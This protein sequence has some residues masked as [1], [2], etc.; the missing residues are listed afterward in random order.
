MFPTKM[1]HLTGVL[2]NKTE[3]FPWQRIAEMQEGQDEN[4][5]QISFH[6]RIVPFHPSSF[7]AASRLP[8]FSRP[9]SLNGPHKLKY[10]VATTRSTDLWPF[11]STFPLCLS[12]FGKIDVI[13]SSNI[14]CIV[15]C[16][17]ELLWFDLLRML[18]IIKP[19]VRII[20]VSPFNWTTITSPRFNS[21]PTP[22]QVFCA[23]TRN[24][25]QNAILGGIN[26]ITQSHSRVF[27]APRP[28]TPVTISLAVRIANGE[29][30][31]PFA[32]DI[33]EVVWISLYMATALYSDDVSATNK[34][35]E[36]TPTSNSRGTST[37]KNSGSS[38]PQNC[39]GY[40]GEKCTQKSKGSVN[41]EL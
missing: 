3:R 15:C 10:C 9:H 35:G 5:N 20:A 2:A 31:G 29:N 17:R 24:C 18:M 6:L 25:A 33:I 30:G 38:T 34:D 19:P 13:R 37:E 36:E 21:V 26:R 12:L 28:L 32:F 39:S 1:G 22:S 16:W 23:S 14:G 11:G 4:G 40:W 7:R 27:V 8:T 41:I